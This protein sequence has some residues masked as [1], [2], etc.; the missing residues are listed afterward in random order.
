MRRL[1]LGAGWLLWLPMTSATIAAER[2]LSVTIY[3]GDLALVQDRRDIEV[4]AGRQRIEFQDV[5]AQ[6]RPE[7][8]SLTASDISI[9]EQNFDFDLLTPAKLMEKAVGHEVTIVRVNPATGAEIREQAEVLATNGG[10]VL[11]IGQ[12]IE[13][14]RDDGLPVRVIFDKVPD[15]LRAR[16]TLSVTVVVG[17]AGTRTA[18]LSYL[19]PGLGWRADYVALFNE[20]DSKIDVQGWVTLTNS[21]GVTYD[22]AQT[23]LVAGSPA[24][25]EGGGRPANYYHPQ[26]PRPTLQEAGTESG[27]RERLGDYYLYP[28]AERTTIANLQT[29]QV[30][31]LDV[32]DVPAEHGYEFR[33]RWLGSAETPQSAKSVYSFSTSARAGLGD[34]LPAGILRFYLRD[35]R[36]DPQFIGESRIDHTPMGSTLS[37]ATG[38]AFDVKVRAVVDKRTRVS[39]FD[40]QSD[41]RYELSNAS[42]RPVTVKLLQEGLWGDSR[43]TAESL[44]STRR[45]ADTAEWAVTVPANGKASLTAAFETRY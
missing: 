39:S 33:N 25:A 22:N 14:L 6:I 21:S 30:S 13:V 23:L 44:K 34:Q 8:V 38:D 40:W 24:L 26:P 36:G 2:T 32:H 4:K 7:T 12:R 11:K 19:T 15:N 45:S 5:S 9:V 29:K 18:T 1:L 16:P 42:P 10:V 28:L 31:F 17:H 43:I 20:G 37:L 41:M 27:S 35:K 3:A